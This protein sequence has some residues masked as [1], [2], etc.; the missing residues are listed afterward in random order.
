[1]SGGDRV[2]LEFMVPSRGLFGYR[3][4]FLT[5]TRGEGVMSSVYDHYEEF[6]GEIPHR[7]VGALVCYETGET[8]QYALYYVQERG[9]LFIASGQRAS[10]DTGGV[11]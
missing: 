7:S 9:T 3:S 8:T 2:R 6:K 4:E 10:A 11:P 1:M 5:D